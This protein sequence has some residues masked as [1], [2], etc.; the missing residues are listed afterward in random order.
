MEQSIYPV[1]YV[2]RLRGGTAHVLL[3]N[4]G[5]EYVVKWY[6]VKKKRQKEVVHEYLVAKLAQLLSLPIIP[7]KL[8][9]IPED[10]IKKTPELK[11]KKH[12]YISRYHFGYVYIEN[13]TVFENV[14]ENPLSETEVKNR[15][16]LAGITVFDQWLN[17]IPTE[18]H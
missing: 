3:F 4:D 10:F 11:Q 9:Y 14:R 17:I 6:G 8:V 18:V 5:K 16:M 1:K 2:Q 15:D 13:C 7:F 12:N